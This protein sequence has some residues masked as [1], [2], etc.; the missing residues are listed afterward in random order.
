MKT[1]TE[2]PSPPERPEDSHKGTFGHLL[3]L[4]G[5]TRMGGAAILTSRAA[6]RSGPGLVTLGLPAP[7][8]P[9]VAP[10]VPSCLTLPLPATREGSFS[11][12]AIQPALDFLGGKVTAVAMGPGLTTDDDTVQFAMRVA[13]RSRVPLV[14]DAD[15]LNCAAKMPA[16]LRASQSPRV[17]TPHPGEASRLLG[18]KTAAVQED[19]VGAATEI[20]ATFS[21]VVVLKG[22]RTLVTDGD[23]LYENRTGNAGMATG[24]MGDVLTGIVGGLLAQGMEPFDAAVLGVHVHGRAGDLAAEEVGRISLV[25]EDLERWLGPAFRSLA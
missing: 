7:L 16:P 22:H 24:G 18:R 12:D 14:L 17:L 13:Q 11:R 21:A 5:S 4:A 9:F 25:A 20:A 10:A 19:R 23:R 15:G 1:V 3:V 8:Q 6:L 2:I